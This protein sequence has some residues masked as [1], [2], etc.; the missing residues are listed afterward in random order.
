MSTANAMSASAV[1][2]KDVSDARSVTVTCVESER[3]NAT[4]VTPVTVVR[5][6]AVSLRL[7]GEKGE[8]GGAPTGWMARPCVQ[9][10]PMLTK[11]SL[12]E[13]A[14]TVE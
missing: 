11:L 8:G 10:G 1:A 12:L 4:S 5:G 13:P 9:E 2:R 3:R 14:K 7:C 6:A